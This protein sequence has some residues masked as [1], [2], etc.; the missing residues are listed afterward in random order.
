MN[1]RENN[2]KL[3]GIIYRKRE[4]MERGEWKER[5]ACIKWKK[6]IGYK[7]KRGLAQLTSSRW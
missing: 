4:Y 5:G 3:Y 6:A 1:E 7:D 2:K